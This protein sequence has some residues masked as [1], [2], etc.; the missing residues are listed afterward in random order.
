MFSFPST[1]SE[2]VPFILSFFHFALRLLVIFTR[3]LLQSPREVY[4]ASQ[5]V[6]QVACLEQ[7]E[8]VEE[9]E[10][11]IDVPENDEL[12]ALQRLDGI[13][14]EVDD[15]S[16]DSFELR[17]FSMQGATIDLHKLEEK[18]R[19]LKRPVRMSPVVDS[20][21]I[22][23][24]GPKSAMQLAVPQLRISGLQEDAE[25]RCSCLFAM[26]FVMREVWDLPQH[27]E[28]LRDMSLTSEWIDLGPKTTSCSNC[29]GRGGTSK[30]LGELLRERLREALQGT[31]LYVLMDSN[32][33]LPG[34]DLMRVDFVGEL[35]PEVW[36]AAVRIGL[37]CEALG[38]YL[39]RR[40]GCMFWLPK[41]AAELQTRL[42]NQVTAALDCKEARRVEIGSGFGLED[43]D[44]DDFEDLAGNI[45]AILRNQAP[46][47]W[48]RLEWTPAGEQL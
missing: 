38:V 6:R 19:I 31:A 25:L 48:Q 36:D 12:E 26:H 11:A 23:V 29:T 14:E 7:D 30:P 5:E 17:V 24:L 40:C 8:E 37:S 15:N 21:G 46:P 16:L 47:G 32:P 20:D 42:E 45:S 27:E 1:M 35:K 18:V 3:A 43:L 2:V 22:S 9:V 44:I 4:L 28:E 34:G 39:E 10:A 41:D 33:W 13:V